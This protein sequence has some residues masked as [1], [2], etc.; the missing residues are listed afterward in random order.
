MSV[1]QPSFPHSGAP[2]ANT[3]RVTTMISCTGVRPLARPDTEAAAR[4][5]ANENH[6]VDR[7]GMRRRWYAN[8]AAILTA[9]LLIIGGVW[10]VTEFSRLQKIAA[11]YEAGRNNCMPLDLARKGR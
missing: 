6:W 8:M 11:C 10:I 3:S 1:R 4:G 2:E 9:A 7:F 5:V